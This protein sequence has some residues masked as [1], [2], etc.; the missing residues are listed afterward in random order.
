MVLNVASPAVVYR[1]LPSAVGTSN[2]LHYWNIQSGFCVFDWTLTDREV[3]CLFLFFQLSR[4]RFTEVNC[5][6]AHGKW[7]SGI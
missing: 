6:S 5:P 3:L 7:L 1:A 4:L 2:S